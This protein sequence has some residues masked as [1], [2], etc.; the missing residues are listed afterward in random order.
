MTDPF[1]DGLE[2][3]PEEAE[4][5][6]G[7]ARALEREVNELDAVEGALE[8]AH[9]LVAATHP[10]L[11]A[12]RLDAIW[13]EIEPGLPSRAE[14][15][16]GS[17]EPRG[18]RRY[19]GWLALTLSGGAA[20]ATLVLVLREEPN[21]AGNS[22]PLPTPPLSLLQAQ[23]ASASAGQQNAGAGTA[24]A[25]G[26]TSTGAPGSDEAAGAIEERDLE[27]AMRPYRAR[28][29]AQLESEYAR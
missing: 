10:D 15:A 18:F 22:S 25:Q 4:E 8:A 16:P 21:L 23:L 5:A 19:L 14:R 26:A 27:Q 6:A 24:T 17:S 7:L 1:A 13:S 9:L 28:W 2:P 11:D 20:V 29:L 12:E 3:T